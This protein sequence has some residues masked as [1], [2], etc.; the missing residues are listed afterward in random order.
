MA[1]LS[2][3]CADARGDFRE[4]AIARTPQGDRLAVV[5]QC[6]QLA[7]GRLLPVVDRP[8]DD[9][10][11]TRFAHL[12]TLHSPP[13]LEVVA[14]LRSQEV[15][16]DQQEND[17]SGID[18]VIKLLILLPAQANLPAVPCADDVLTFE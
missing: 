8:Q 16:T 5:R 18:M 11:D 7:E 10:D 9:R 13:H 2:D 12:V 3:G 14:V 15:G 17:L 6:L 4:G 1:Q